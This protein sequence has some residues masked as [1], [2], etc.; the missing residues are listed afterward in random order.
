MS[1][2]LD[3]FDYDS[4]TK[5]GDAFTLLQKVT[6]YIGGTHIAIANLKAKGLDRSP[7]MSSFLSNLDTAKV[8][9]AA[10]ETR[11]EELRTDHK[12]QEIIGTPQILLA[13]LLDFDAD[14]GTQFIVAIKA[15]YPNI[16]WLARVM[17]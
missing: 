6:D 16:S 1:N 8:V 15:K 14:L 13:E 10:L 5:L 17:S 2:F 11:I 3:T 7:E 4:V 9:R 12:S